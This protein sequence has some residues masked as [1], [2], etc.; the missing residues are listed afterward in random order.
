M[1][2]TAARAASAISRRPERW[3]RT[4]SARSR[5]SPGWLPAPRQTPA[6]RAAATRCPPQ[7]PPGKERALSTR[8]RLGLGLCGGG[9]LG[10]KEAAGRRVMVEQLGVAA[11]ADGRLELRL[12]FF[13]A[14]VFVEQVFEERVRQAVVGLGL[15]RAR[16]LAYERDVFQSGGAKQFL[17]AQDIGLGEG[18]ALGR[19]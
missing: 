15:E 18:A 10:Q 2:T 8:G 13:L 1:R 17:A 14:E 16:D 11:P 12:G 4:S 19:N 9:F 7:S 5:T 3:R 6:D